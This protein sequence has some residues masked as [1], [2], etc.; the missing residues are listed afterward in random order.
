LNSHYEHIVSIS[1]TSQ[2]SGTWQAAVAAAKRVSTPGKIS[3][4]DSRS[5]SL[6][7]GLITMYAAE[8]ARAGYSGDEVVAATEKIMAATQTFGLI[9]DLTCAVRGGRIGKGQK[10]LADLLRVMP[11]LILSEDGRVKTGSLVRRHGHPVKRFARY[12]TRRLDPSKT[13]RVAVGHAD[14][15]DH[16]EQLRDALVIAVGSLDAVYLT[17]IGS[18]LG[19]HGGPGALVAAF[20]EYS[21]P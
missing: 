19:A 15:R 5:V 10:W 8:C 7:Q 17:E 2:V 11:I 12:I 18:V 3:V 6:G 1:V 4:I 16:A 21:P 14:C 9:P 13:Y 20:Q